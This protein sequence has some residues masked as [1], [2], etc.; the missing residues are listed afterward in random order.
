M[1]E[2]ERML[3][4]YEGK[5]IDS[6]DHRDADIVRVR[7]TGAR[8]NQPR[9]LT[10]A[11]HEN[12][13]REP[14]P[15]SWVREEL[16]PPGVDSPLFGFLDITS[17]TNERTIRAAAL[18]KSGVGHVVPLWFGCRPFAMLALM[19]SFVCD[20]VARQKVAGLHLTYTYLKQIPFPAP[21]SLCPTAW[22][23]G[24]SASSWLERRA[25]YLSRTS[26]S[27]RCGDGGGIYPWDAPKRERVLV[28]IDAGA[29]HLYGVTRDE[30][31]YILDSF[32]TVKRKD[33]AAHG[34]YRT[35]RLILETY[36]AMTQAIETGVPYDSPFDDLLTEGS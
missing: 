17:P 20:F 7:S 26:E 10:E 28:E 21:T 23:L 24:A 19:N 18:P 32:T 16:I 5:M 14:I 34:E 8:Q 13:N 6:Y 11:E 1:T 12:V 27:L 2:V 33:I 36:D 30:A 29:F 4:L 3:P 35:K 25:E 31:D 9:Y 15:A 22:T